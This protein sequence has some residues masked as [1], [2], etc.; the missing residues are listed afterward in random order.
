MTAQ[1][2]ATR[3]AVHGENVAGGHAHVVARTSTIAFDGSAATG[4][5][6]PGPADLLAA[7]L[8][9]CI[10]KNVER[11]SHLLPFRYRR[12]TV[13]VAVE[14]EEPPPRIVRARYTLRVETDEPDRRVELLHRNIRTFGTITNT[15]A[16]AC[17]LQGEIVAIRAAH[18]PVPGGGSPPEDGAPDGDPA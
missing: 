7:A 13:D 4:D 15:L 17:D 11:F 3:Y 6:L 12:A 5:L 2:A 14:R 16:R 1:G 9:A 8:A 10:L 18:G